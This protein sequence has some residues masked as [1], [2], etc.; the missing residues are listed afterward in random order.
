MD[1]CIIR[2]LLSLAVAMGAFSAQ[3]WQT[4]GVFQPHVIYGEDDRL[5]LYQVEDESML[6]LARSTVLLV[7]N[8]SLQSTEEGD[9]RL[10]L[11]N[12]GTDYRL[13]HSEPFR[14]QHIAGFCSGFLVGPDTII[15]AGHCI[16]SQ[17]NCNNTSFVFDYAIKEEGIHPESV[18]P[19]NVYRCA[20]VIRSEAS[21]ADF[22]VIK[23]DR[24]VENREPLE[25]NL[26]GSPAPGTPLT[27]IGHPAGIPTKV[28]GGAEVRRVV[29]STHFVANVD[30]YGGNSG[31]A[32]FNSTTGAVEGILVR[33]ETD[34]VIRNGCYISNV[35]SQNGCRGE[36]VTLISNVLPYLV[37]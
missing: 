30:T 25:L 17:V 19:S 16:R 18:D 29:G 10:R 35:C 23:L 32:V 21:S 24:P 31:S 14:E 22:A 2:T 7:N 8:S 5:D 28:A 6:Q 27:V 26:T 4:D 33:G 34:F 36:D 37:H 12:Y 11:T 15:T 1:R 13:C 3:A 20:R 9:L